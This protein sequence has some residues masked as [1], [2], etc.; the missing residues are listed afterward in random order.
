MAR[1]GQHERCDVPEYVPGPTYLANTLC[2]LTGIYIPTWR[3]VRERLERSEMS[4]DVC[5]TFHYVFELVVLKVICTIVSAIKCKMA[6]IS[7]ET[8][9]GGICFFT[10]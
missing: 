7:M 3:L 10:S 5:A 8:N 4:H 6:A 1:K 9:P 2:Q